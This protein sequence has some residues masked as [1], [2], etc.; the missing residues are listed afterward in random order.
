MVLSRRSFG[1][2][3]RPIDDPPGRVPGT[4]AMPIEVQCQCCRR[5]RARDELAGRWVRCPACQQGVLVPLPEAE[6]ERDA[7]ALADEAPVRAAPAPAPPPRWT[8]PD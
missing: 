4:R 8:R 5:M 3:S 2:I 6:D 7:F 1:T